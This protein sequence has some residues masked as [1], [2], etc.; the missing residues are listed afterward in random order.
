MVVARAILLAEKRAGM[1]GDTNTYDYEP[2][3]VDSQFVDNYDIDSLAS[4]LMGA[5]EAAANTYS[6][7]GGDEARVPF[8]PETSISDYVGVI[9]AVTTLAK[10]SFI[11][12]FGKDIN[13]EEPD[14][15]KLAADAIEESV[16]A[17]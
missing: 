9:L 16:F 6:D 17:E 12:A 2:L 3:T 11:A 14:L 13:S 1:G 7:L 5:G 15:P 4:A 8:S 10:L